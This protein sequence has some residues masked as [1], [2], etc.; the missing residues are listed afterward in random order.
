ME[1]CIQAQSEKE[2]QAFLDDHKDMLDKALKSAR[3]QHNKDQVGLMLDYL[4]RTCWTRP[5]S[6]PANNTTR[7]R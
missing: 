1:L 7:I 5:S 2:Y 3:E 6:R 4:T